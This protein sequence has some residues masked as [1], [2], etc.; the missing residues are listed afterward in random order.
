MNPALHHRSQTRALTSL[1][2]RAPDDG[3]GG[4]GSTEAGG[5]TETGGG[6]STI[7][8]GGGQDDLPW[9]STLPDDL[10]G[11][12]TVVRFKSQADAISNMVGL[13]KRLGAPADQ[14]LRV[15]TKP[16]DMDAFAKDV[17]KRLGAP[18]TAEG[19][20]LEWEGQTEAE[21]A[22]AGE[23]AKHMFEKGGFPPSAVSAAV[24]FWRGR[25]AAEEAAEIEADKQ[26]AAAAET[27]LRTEW[28]AA[29]DTTKGEIGK[30][31][32]E[33]GGD[34][35]VQELDLNTGLGSSPELARF[36]K[37]VVDMRAE[38]GPTGD[39]QRAKTGDTP[40]TPGEARAARAMLEGDPVKS[41]ALFN[42]DDPMHK[43]VVEE[44]NRYFAMENPGLHQKA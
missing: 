12:P 38:G 23:F 13:E 33:L 43:S 42:R 10:K 25:V 20:K 32:A 27:A 30:L 4:G 40:M 26:A 18:E 37:K 36:L 17:F 16:E 28:G 31:I 34:K 44:R 5:S 41:K 39:G 9:Y 11:N 6:G 21:K 15:P 3:A 8:G 35:L 1:T 19:Y 7:Q 14:L 24:E 29:F 2:T 22:V